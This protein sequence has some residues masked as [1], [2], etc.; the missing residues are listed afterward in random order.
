MSTIKKE[1]KHITKCPHCNQVLKKWTT[2]P[3]NY[4][5][6]LG[7]GAETLY[8]CFNDECPLYKKAWNTMYENYGRVGSM[9]YWFNPQDGDEGVLPVGNAD[10]MKGDIT[11]DAE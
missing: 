11:G 8:V 5:D 10:A 4:S 7:F 3:F 6:G 9:R 2:S 1:R